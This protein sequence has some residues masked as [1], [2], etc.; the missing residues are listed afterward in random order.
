MVQTAENV[1]ARHAISTAEQHEVV[2][3]R[4]AQYQDALAGDHAFQRRY[5]RLP[6]AVPRPRFDRP[7]GSI[8]GGRLA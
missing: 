6:F 8:A 2:L 5:M 3:Q 7:A 1:A 4:Y